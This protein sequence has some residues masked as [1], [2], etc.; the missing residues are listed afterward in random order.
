MLRERID[1]GTG[2]PFRSDRLL[3]PVSPV[4]VSL[5]LIRPLIEQNADTVQVPNMATVSAVMI[6]QPAHA[7]THR[8]S[9]RFY[10]LP[11]T[12]RS[13]PCRLTPA[14]LISRWP[15]RCRLPIWVSIT[16]FC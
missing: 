13:W 12:W 5:T 7:G 16:K 1:A 15:W 8:R 3:P 4:P 6:K 11:P 9:F 10:V 2:L 14:T